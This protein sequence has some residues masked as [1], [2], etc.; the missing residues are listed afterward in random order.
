MKVDNLNLF[1]SHRDKY[2]PAFRFYSK[3]VSTSKTLP[4]ISRFINKKLYSLGIGSVI[5]R[6]DNSFTIYFSSAD[7]KL[8]KQYEKNDIFCN[9][10]SGAFFHKRWKNYDYPGQTSYYKSIQGKSGVDFHA[11]DL[12]SNELIIPEKNNSV[13]LIYCSHT[14]EHLDT[15]SAERFLRECLRILKKNGVMRL[16]LPNTKNDF[17]LNRSLLKQAGATKKLK[18]N[19]LRD[20]AG[21]LLSDTKL[22]SMQK[23]KKLSNSSKTDSRKLYNILKKKDKKLLKFDGNN[24]ERH[25]SYWDNEEL[26]KFSKKIG[27]RLCIPVYQNTSCA[28]PFSNINVFDITNPHISFYVELIK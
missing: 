4:K 7:K 24:S 21:L 20:A 27:F 5:N 14:L 19:Y 6:Y 11:I 8:Y 16:M 26:I 25:I 18:E 17:Y 12:C 9:F 23:I 22:Y 15:N 1:S 3:K 10:G 28:T 13:S 2:L